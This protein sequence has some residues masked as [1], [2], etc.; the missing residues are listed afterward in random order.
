MTFKHIL[1]SLVAVLAFVATADAQLALNTTTLSAAVSSASI[2]T[3]SVTSAAGMTVTPATQLYVG[4]ESM[5]ILGVSG[6]TITVARGQS[7]TKAAPHIVAETVIIASPDQF[8]TTD[9]AF[10]S[11]C[12]A[13]LTYV[14]PWVNVATG[15]E[16]LCST[17][18]LSWVPGFNNGTAARGKPTA[19]VASAAGLITPTGPLFHITG[20][21]AITGFTIP[22]GFRGGT[23]CAIPDG[24]FTTT[25]AANIALAST[26]VVNRTLCWT[27]DPSAGK[28]FFPTY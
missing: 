3:I 4:F 20:T 27:Y 13:A 10:G 9:P 19:A 23:F 5:L 11:G 16:W 25:T 14:T 7:G 28:L 18:S 8:Y 17:V 6:T 26:A 1:T 2:Q 15:N 22:T 24:I 12:T 21:A